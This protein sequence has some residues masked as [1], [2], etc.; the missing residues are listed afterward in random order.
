MV[1][2]REKTYI[3]IRYF[4]PPDLLEFLAAEALQLGR[5]YPVHCI[6]D[7]QVKLLDNNNANSMKKK[8]CALV[9]SRVKRLSIT[10]R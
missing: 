8:T 5:F 3:Y 1:N 9:L 6:V 7:E 10:S 4:K 2:K